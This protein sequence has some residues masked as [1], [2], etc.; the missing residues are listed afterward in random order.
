MALEIDNLKF[1]KVDN[2]AKKQ[3]CLNWKPK[4]PDFDAFGLK[5]LKTIGILEIST[6]KFD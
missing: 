5:F 2:F 6:L 4:K 3:K 1:A